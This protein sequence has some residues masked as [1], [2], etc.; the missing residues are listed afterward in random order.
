MGARSGDPTTRVKDHESGAALAGTSHEAY[1]RT[2][3]AAEETRS[4]LPSAR[5]V[6]DDMFRVS[7]AQ[8]L[9]EGI[10]CNEVLHAT[11]PSTRSHE[12]YTLQ[13]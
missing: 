10:N 7:E 5:A 12:S 2:V 13:V 4:A 1:D 3:G 9:K 6:P 8:K 11:E